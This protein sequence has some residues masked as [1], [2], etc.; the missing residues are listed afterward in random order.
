MLNQ[1]LQADPENFKARQRKV[2]NLLK[3]GELDEAK[4]LINETEKYA[5]SLEEKA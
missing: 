3:M 1:V 2:H 5:Y 4:K